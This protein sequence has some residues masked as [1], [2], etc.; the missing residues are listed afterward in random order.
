MCCSSLLFA[1]SEHGETEKQDIIVQMFFTNSPELLLLTTYF[2]TSVC[3]VVL[4]CFLKVRASAL[5]LHENDK[6]RKFCATDRNSLM[7]Q[8]IIKQI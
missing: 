4:E 5:H 8:Q 1:F 2:Y 7:Q 3:V 6:E